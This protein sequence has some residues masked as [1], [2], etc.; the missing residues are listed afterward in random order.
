MTAA[1][2]GMEFIEPSIM[3]LGLVWGEL[4]A[5]SIWDLDGSMEAWHGL[6]C[7]HARQ[8][9]IMIIVSGF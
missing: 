9:L 2:G 7:L 4:T 5:A 3:G 1:W 8:V 6:D